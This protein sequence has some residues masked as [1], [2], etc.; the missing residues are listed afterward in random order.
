[1]PPAIIAVLRLVH[2]LAAQ[3]LLA[4]VLAFVWQLAPEHAHQD[5]DSHA[6][7][8]VH[9]H[10]APHAWAIDAHHNELSVGGEDDDD[11]VVW[12]DGATLHSASYKLST[13]SVTLAAIA[14]AAASRPTWF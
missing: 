7:A 1:M 6:A 2:R 4:P 9:S 13:P 8:V 3:L 11:D 5:H 14:S 12:L 10:V